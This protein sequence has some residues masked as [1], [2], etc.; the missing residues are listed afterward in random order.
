[1][2]D[3]VSKRYVFF[4]ISALVIL[5]G[6]I[7]LVLPGGIH[8]G[9][10]FTS[11]SIITLRFP[12]RVD[13]GQLRDAFADLGHPEAIVQRAE[14]VYIVRTRPLAPEERDAAGNVTRPTE[15]QQLEQALIQRFGGV[16]DET[17]QPRVVVGFDSVSPLVAT[18]IVQKSVLAVLAACMGILLYLSW[19]FRK[20]KGAWRYG[21]CA[22]FGLVHDALLVL[23]VFSILGR[24]FGLELDAL[25]IT[26]VL[27]VI[28]FSVHDTIVVFDR[29]RENLSRYLGESFATV[30][31]HSLTQTLGR[32]LNTSI[33]VLL[34]L[35][36]LLLFGGVTIR[37]FVLAL[38]IGIAAGTYSSIF[39]ASMLLVI[40]ENGELGRLFGRGPKQPEPA[41]AT[42]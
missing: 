23:G 16:P 3:F 31:N 15:R 8:P 13:Q 18:E 5:P 12:Q 24:L 7:S 38:L 33:T 9:I 34:T 14:D 36:T 6:L 4:L 35:T 2:I 28:G 22:V 17:G 32:S 11:G 1:V 25:F 26:A 27:T 37:S 40:W 21:A 30:V 41:A 20:V 42:A 29:I 39:N 19:A 10:D